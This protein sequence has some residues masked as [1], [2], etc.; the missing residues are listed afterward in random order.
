MTEM[1][2]RKINNYIPTGSVKISKPAG[3][4]WNRIRYNMYQC[5]LTKVE[6][7]RRGMMKE[8]EPYLP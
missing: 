3:M 7:R 2:T 6:R 5:R 8:E 1:K 4:V